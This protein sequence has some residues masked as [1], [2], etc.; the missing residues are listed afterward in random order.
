MSQ[1]SDLIRTYPPEKLAPE[2]RAYPD[3]RILNL[4]WSDPSQLIPMCEKMGWNTVEDV[5]AWVVKVNAAI[6]NTSAFVSMIDPHID[7]DYDALARVDFAAIHRAVNEQCN[8]RSD[9]W[10]DQSDATYRLPTKEMLQKLATEF[11]GRTRK[12]LDTRHDCDDYVRQ[13][14]GWL[15]A[16]G[17]GNLACAFCTQTPYRSGS[18]IGGHATVIAVDNLLKVWIIEPQ[19]GVLYEPKSIQAARLGGYWT[20]DSMKLARVY[21]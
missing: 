18:M 11:P 20:A 14:L 15:A 2:L 5:S 21:F 8:I 19:D 4:L 13:F 17:V 6:G 16:N 3:F 10:F 7:I 1:L 12:W 9:V